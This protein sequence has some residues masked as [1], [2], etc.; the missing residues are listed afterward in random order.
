MLKRSDF[1]AL[2]YKFVHRKTE[3]GDV[4]SA[5]CGD[6]G[7]SVIDSDGRVESVKA[8]VMPRWVTLLPTV[9]TCL[10]SDLSVLLQ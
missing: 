1:V 8:V 3:L 7:L 6:A 4:A 5:A 9:V 10:L 2:I